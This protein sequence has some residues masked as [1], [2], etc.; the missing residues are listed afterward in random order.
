MTDQTIRVM[1]DASTFENGAVAPAGRG[2]ELARLLALAG[3]ETAVHAP[4]DRLPF[5]DSGPATHPERWRELGEHMREHE[6]SDEPSLARLRDEFC[7]TPPEYWLV[8]LCAAAERYLEAA[9]AMGI[10]MDEQQAH[11]VTPL[12]FAQLLHAAR[13]LPVEEGLCA[14]LG[15]GTPARLGLLEAAEPPHGKPASHQGLRLAA[16]E[17]PLLLGEQTTR[18][19]SSLLVPQSD[20]FRPAFEEPLLHVAA[21]LL[22]QGRVLCLRGP[23]PRALRQFSADLAGWLKLEPR[24]LPA[25]DGNLRLASILRLRRA[26]PI[27]DIT[28]TGTNVAQPSQPLRDALLEAQRSLPRLAVL[29][30]DSFSESEIPSLAVPRLGWRE[31]AR[32]WLAATG[33]ES[34]ARRL[35]TRFRVNLA[36]AAA[37]CRHAAQI[38]AAQADGDAPARE[39]LIAAQ[40]LQEGGRR[41]GRLVTHL[42]SEATLADLVAPDSLREQLRDIIGWQRHSH[43]VFGE[44]GIGRRSPLGRGLTCLFSGPP[45][46]G[47]TFA[48]QCLANELGLNLYRI[49]LSQVVSKYIGET[50]KALS[51]VFDEAEAGHGVLLFD[52]ADAL[53]G[54]RSEVKDAH[55]RYANIEVGYLLQ[56]FDA[57]E[58][59]AILATNLRSNLDPAF[60][61]RIRF[62]LDFPMPD[63]AMRRRLWEQSLPDEDYRSEDVDLGAFVERFR[64]SGGSIQN[65]S[66][67]AAH[68]AAAT[69]EG[70]VTVQHLVR[71]TY[72]ELEKSGQT[73]DRASFGPLADHLPA[74]VA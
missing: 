62:M 68:M 63:T 21:S 6:V 16:A 69:P 53:F 67:A 31:A 2:I 10:L 29:A 12:A 56:R 3:A 49:D 40:V 19:R 27:L 55:D 5:D 23:S 74:E 73:H 39:R 72:R 70:R 18:D 25:G 41:M 14:A 13:G 71:A 24:F 33:D 47:K 48:A 46:T 20:D 64:L 17:I 44:M 65:I 42:E 1:R 38:A 15:G 11:L 37:A 59:V 7:L 34:L 51:T 35:A 58:G 50:E 4:K 57:F 32:I 9:T 61:R 26:L 22:E 30:G 52:E 54:K 36:E 45:G 43:R 8:M 66:L 60:V 28:P